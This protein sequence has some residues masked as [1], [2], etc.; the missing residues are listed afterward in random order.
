MGRSREG[1]KVGCYL[2]PQMFMS[3]QALGSQEV[4]LGGAIFKRGDVLGGIF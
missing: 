1:K 4:L 2:F 3:Y